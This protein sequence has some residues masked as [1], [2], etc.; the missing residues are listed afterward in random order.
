MTSLLQTMVGSIEPPT[1]FLVPLGG[2]GAPTAPVALPPGGLSIGRT[3]ES[4]LALLSRAVSREHARITSRRGRWFIIDAGS[5]HGTF[6]NGVRLQARIAAPME[7]GDMVRFGPVSFR[8]ASE[9]MARGTDSRDIGL[10]HG[11]AMARVGEEANRTLAA[12]GVDRLL[13]A[14]TRITGA[15]DEAALIEALLDGAAELTGMHRALLISARTDTPQVVAERGPPEG[16]TSSSAQVTF[17]RSVV[18]EAAAGFA[19]RVTRGSI[20]SEAVSIAGLGVHTAVAVPVLVGEATAYVLYL[21]ARDFEPEGSNEAVAYATAIAQLAGNAFAAIGQREV[22][23]RQRRME[24]ELKA[25]RD[26]QA[27]LLPP[28]EGVVNGLAYAHRARPGD[29]VAGDFVDILPL[30]DGRVGLCLG[31]VTGHGFDSAIIMAA[32]ISRTRSLLAAGADVETVARALNDSLVAHAEVGRFASMFLAVLAPATGEMEFID[33]GHGYAVIR[34]STGGLRPAGDGEGSML[35]GV[36]PDGTFH[37][38]VGRM[39]PGE[40]LIVFSDGIVESV[41][42]AGEQFG[43]ARIADA[44]ARTDSPAADVEACLEAMGAFASASGNEDDVTIISV[45]R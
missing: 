1:A 11:T 8:L 31:D 26:A 13:N 28:P 27:L 9:A 22:E 34:E 6:L 10:A 21:D 42:S 15:P 43:R 5:R 2:E 39:A 24:R 37:R 3:Q 14:A 44:L 36:L 12:R 16:R 17:S 20:G 4:G 35:L 25:A 32:V 29:V 40:R 19:A 23:S 41:S 33:C 45:A 30:P 18:R 7:V 38:C